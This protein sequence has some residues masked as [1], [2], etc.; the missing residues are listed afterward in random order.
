MSGCF[1]SGRRRAA[2]QS[3]YVL[4][5]GAL[6][7][8]FVLVPAAGLAI[9][10]GMMYLVKSLLSAAS[11]GAALAGA[12]ALSRGSDDGSQRANAEATANAYLAANF[13]AGY[14]WSRDLQVNSVAGSDSQYVRFLTT[15]ASVQLPLVFLR[16]FR[17]ESATVSASSKATRRDVNIMYVMDRS[18]S[19]QGAPCTQL[20]NA[21]K[22]FIDHFAEGRDNVGLITFGTSSLVDNP[23]STTFKTAINTT[24]NNVT[25]SGATNTA[26]ALWQAYDKLVAL[27]QTGALNAILL[28]TDGLPTA[29]TQTYSILSTSHCNDRVNPKQ[30]AAYAIS[31]PS[32][33]SGLYQWVGSAQPMASDLSVLTT[34]TT[35]NC[36]FRTSGA[37]S[38]YRDVVNAPLT[39]SSGNSLVSTGFKNAS[40]HL[41]GGLLA[42]NYLNWGAMNAADHA[43]LRIRR[44]DPDPDRGGNSLSGVVIYAIG[45]NMDSDGQTLLKRIVNDPSLSPNPVAAGAQGRCEYA[46]DP[47]QLNDA[48]TRVASQLLRLAQ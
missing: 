20:K 34:P 48:F 43:A 6:T 14:M 8:F 44:G 39:D 7:L 12:R 38:L 17:T 31:S 35:T 13:P 33:P 4:I 19:L 3:G 30:G 41:S 21:T 32:N 26:Q 28:F 5:F 1:S 29:V 47:A 2:R 27:N 22:W 36:Y 23:L 45:Y 15:T 18:T 42:L 10:V 37:S 9:D 16:F 25:C 40:A 46:G 11:D 24:V